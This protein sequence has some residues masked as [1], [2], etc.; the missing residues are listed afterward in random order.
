MK[1][2][3]KVFIAVVPSNGINQ[4]QLELEVKGSSQNKTK[5]MKYYFAEL[6]KYFLLT[7]MKAESSGTDLKLTANQLAPRQGQAD[8]I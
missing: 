4:G 6:V 3:R 8:T 7:L 1:E 5:V 2:P